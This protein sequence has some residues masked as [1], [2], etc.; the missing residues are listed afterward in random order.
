[1]ARSI[2]EM[3]DLSSKVA[4]VTGGAVGIGK[5]IVQRLHEAGAAVVVADMNE[6]AARQ[7]VDELNT[8]KPDSALAVRVDVSNEDDVKA[9]VEATISRFGHVDILV[10]NAGI[11]PFKL[12]T[13]ADAALYRKVFEVDMLGVFLCTQAVT[14]QM[15]SQGGGKVINIS[16]VDALHPTSIGL[17]HYDA[18]KHGVWGFTKNIA[19]ELAPHN[20]TVNAIAPGVVATP[21]VADL[22]SGGSTAANV[23]IPLGR[24]AEPD[25]I[26]KAVLFIASGLSD[27]MTA[28]QVVVDGGLLAA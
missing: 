28:S 9:M 24:V 3:L 12:F 4:I 19:L 20:I 26:A 1:M 8:N 6:G 23:N 14:R 18:M 27:Y 11:Y 5:G 13:E 21:G 10:N 17:A 22:S 7:T 25:D 2:N 15:I 16:S